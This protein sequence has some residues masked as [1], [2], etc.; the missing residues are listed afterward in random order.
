MKIGRSC[1]IKKKKN[2]KLS[3]L[4]SLENDPLKYYKFSNKINTLSKGFKKIKISFLANFTIELIEP[5]IKVELVKRNLNPEIYFAPYDQIEQE[6][7]NVNSK[8]YQK[9]NDVIVKAIRLEN[10]LS[11]LFTDLNPTIELASN[12]SRPFTKLISSIA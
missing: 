9:R 7:Y 5:F 2:N 11:E 3:F 1:F 12:F 6:V 8:I 4:D 10:L